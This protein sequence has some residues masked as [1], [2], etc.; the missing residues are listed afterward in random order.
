MWLHPRSF[1]AAEVVDR[2]RWQLEGA[3]DGA[4]ATIRSAIVRVRISPE[5]V[6]P[7]GAH[8]RGLWGAGPDDGVHSGL[9]RVQGMLGH[10]GVLTATASGGRTPSDR[11]ALVPWGD[12]PLVAREL[13]SP[14]PGALP[15]PAPATVY[16]I[17][18]PI[19]VHDVRGRT[20][21]VDERGRLSG[22]PAVLVA[23]TGARRELSAWAGP[24]PL[25]ERWW[26]AAAARRQ[27]RFQV[28]DTTGSAWL[29]VLDENGWWAEG[30][31]D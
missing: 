7:V 26:D 31:Y 2:V 20:V 18:R 3:R 30:R 9:S 24:W 27:Q 23:P 5:S 17:P 1:V 12:R 28:V 10:E 16:A 4:V 13:R 19:V 14:W 22:A 8:E 15:A 6:D 25:E 11:R 29:V 21:A